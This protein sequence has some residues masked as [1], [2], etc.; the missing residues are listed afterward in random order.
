MSLIRGGAGVRSALRCYS[1]VAASQSTAST[2]ASVSSSSSSWK[3]P[4]AP[5]TEP[6]YDE[7]LQYI[8]SQQARLKQ[9]MADLQIEVQKYQPNTIGRQ[10]AEAKLKSYSI[11]SQINDPEVRWEFE[12]NVNG[13]SLSCEQGRDPFP[14]T[15]GI[16]DVAAPLSNPV[17]AHLREKKWRDTRLPRLMERIRLMKVLPDAISYITPTV[18]LQVSFGEGKGFDDHT[19]RTLNQSNQEGQDEDSHSE[20]RLEKQGGDVLAGCFV[21]AENVRFFYLH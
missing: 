7:A 8:S 6:A 13:E 19:R 1:V 14:L 10:I 18:D 5:G 11:A 20:S 17:F 2:S 16:I 15:Q 4:I 3:L 9:K 21:G 12:N